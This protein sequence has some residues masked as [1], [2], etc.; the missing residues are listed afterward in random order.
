M[1]LTF[2]RCGYLGVIAAAALALTL[3]SRSR[4]SLGLE[5]ALIVTACAG[6][7]ALAWL[8]R[9]V[10]RRE[11]LVYYHHEIVVLGLVAGVA[12]VAG[13]PVLSYLDA[14][15]M[16]LGLFLACG[17][18]G[19]LTAGCCHGRPARWGVVYGEHHADHGFTR[20]L[21]GVPLVPVQA[22]EAVLVLCLVAIGSA[23]TLGA[24][25]AG[26]ALTLYI[27][28]YALIR[29]GLEFLRG[30]PLRPYW[31][32]ASEAQWTS[33]LVACLIAAGVVTGV[34]PRQWWHVATAVVLLATL[35]VTVGLARRPPAVLHPRHLQEVVRAV[36]GLSHVS[37]SPRGVAVARTSG[38]VRLSCGRIEDR[39]HIAISGGEPPLDPAQARGLA[40]VI[41]ALR[42][43]ADAEYI[44]GAAS[45]WHV[46]LRDATADGGRARRNGV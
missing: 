4:L 12:A 26:T 43:R 14:T 38:G 22:I 19:C 46:L 16:G 36:A 24:Q 37:E 34:M 13:G 5:A 35:G 23:L 44:A 20:H 27:S 41:S 40:L 30:D 8:T 28:G 10:A 15:A 3:A 1:R 45:V 2:R 31:R 7:L 33:A 29:F 25:P 32:G 42:P 9:L 18:V 21:V 17:R 6:F 11:R 39:L